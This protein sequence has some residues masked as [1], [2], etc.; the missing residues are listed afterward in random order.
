MTVR[1]IGNAGLI[2]VRDNCQLSMR[3]HLSV[4][5][6]V[7]VWF[8]ALSLTAGAQARSTAD[9]LVD[10]TSVSFN[11]TG[12]LS[13]PTI[14]AAVQARPSTIVGDPEG[15]AGLRVF[16]PSAR[17]I[18]VIGPRL[19]VVTNARLFR[20]PIVR[21]EREELLLVLPRGA[22]VAVGE[23]IKV[24][25]RVRTVSGARR[26]VDDRAVRDDINQVLN[27]KRYRGATMLFAESAQTLDG[28]DLVR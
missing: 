21:P 10:D 28:V 12:L 2:W 3:R 15:L 20:E 19:I 11:Q 14:E 16:V 22:D 5:L 9:H 17:V 26:D 1:E 24:V 25:G 27:A 4:L 18:R 13:P 23:V 7:S 8:T 6:N